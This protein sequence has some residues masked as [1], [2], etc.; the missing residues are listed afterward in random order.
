MP[1]PAT[2]RIPRLVYTG[3]GDNIFTLTPAD[4]QVRQLTWS[5]EKKEAGT[6]AQSPSAHLTHTWPAWAPDGSRVA[7]FGLRGMQETGLYAVAYRAV[8]VRKTPRVEVWPESLALGQVLPVMPLWLTLDL[9]VPVR[10]E[11]SY[12]ATC[13]SLRIS[14]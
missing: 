3:A 2:P 11:E 9:C 7:C 6:I 10:L 12:L 8:T 5:W 13:N 1:G 4:G 14:A